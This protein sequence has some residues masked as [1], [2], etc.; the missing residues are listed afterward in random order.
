MPRYTERWGLSVLGSGDSLQA[1]GFK[2]ADADRRLLDRLLSYAAEGHRHTGL[3]GDDL[4]PT[5]AL[6]L[7]LITTGG[8]IASG[9]R[10]YY[11]FTIVD[12]YGNESA[13]SPIA[14]IDTPSTVAMPSAPAISYTAGTGE[15]QPG[16][17][18]YALSAYKGAT[19]QETKA[20][21]T[22]F[23]VI[24]GAS[25][26]NEIVLTLPTLP[27]GADGYNVYRK[28]PSGMHYLWLTSIADPTPLQT[29][30]DDGTISGDCDRSLPSA[31]RTGGTNAVTVRYPGAPPAIG[32]GWSWRVYRTVDP[33]RWGR[34]RLKDI[35]PIGATP[36][37]PLGF[38]DTGLQTSVGS[39]PAKAQ[40]I[41]APPKI[42]LTDG[43]E[44][45]GSLPPGL[46]VAPQMLTFS[47]V[48]PVAQRAGTFTW[49]CDFDMAD[50]IG[51]RLYL[52]AGSKPAAQPVKADI[53]AL[54]GN[55]ATPTWKSL[56]NTPPAIA[57]GQNSTALVTPDRQHLEQGDVLSA[58][59]LQSG[60]GG[61]PTD[62]D[63]TINV[64]LYVKDG[65]ETT[66]HV[67]TT[68]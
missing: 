4:T 53:I 51:I 58:N 32:D 2:F 67:W 11:R 10:Y 33:N 41:N 27:F 22:A 13:P 56:F 9:S 44:V 7:T 26:T 54:R 45:Q 50:I 52:R 66:S 61:T 23:I 48:G 55:E 43:A 20:A 46:L 16:G 39:P 18:S 68:T 17:Y 21:N 1:D 24:P 38:N 49:I 31:N 12:E 60:G 63:L 29:W 8:T 6:N 34:S 42:N 28:T 5:S 25:P 62:F 15:L 57:V 19:T 3:R 64:L 35:T 65:S 30:T 36:A 40:I 47:S 37:T 59:I 14:Y